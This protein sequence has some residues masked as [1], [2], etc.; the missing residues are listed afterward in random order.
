M[1]QICTFHKT[2]Q[3][4]GHIQRNQPCEDAS[5]SYCDENG[6][7]FIA[8]VADGHGQAKSF[9]SGIGSQIAV[10][11]ALLCLKDAAEAILSTPEETESFYCSLLESRHGRQ[12]R[13]KQ[14]T[15]TILSQWSDGIWQDYSATPPTQDELGE[16]AQYY[17]DDGNVPKI[18]GTTLIAALWLPK[19]LLLLQQGDGRCDVLYADG[20]VDQPIPWDERCEGNR[21]SS[22]CDEDAADRIRHCVINLEEKQV[23]A[24]YLGS[25]GVED[26]YRNQ[27]GTHIFYKDLSCVLAV[28]DDK[29]FDSYL[30]ELLPDFSARGR[31]GKNGSMDDVSVAGIAD[32]EKLAQ[33]TAG[34]QTDILRFQLEEDIFWKEDTLRSKMR[35]HDILQKRSMEA[36]VQLRQ[37][38]NLLDVQRNRY[39]Q[40]LEQRDQMQSAIEQLE[41]KI[42]W[43]NT[44][45]DDILRRINKAVKSAV[46]LDLETKRNG[47]MTN[48]D[49]LQEEI[50]NQEAVI[51]Q[52]EADCQHQ[53]E[54]ET[55]VKAEFTEY[56]TQYQE[57][58]GQ[59][60]TLR[61]ELSMLGEISE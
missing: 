19:C 30:E 3:G 24:C 14:L 15:D 17:A 22:V 23:A 48:L 12:T 10:E 33:L 4:Y 55:N 32:K 51:Q 43:Q 40:M 46:G 7:F 11:V 9:R 6:K 16:Y 13:I 18:Y 44:S 50:R 59:I 25:D 49:A 56:D 53:A 35:K 38:E 28:K 58:A 29:D 57:I 37:I 47:M 26:A 36:E 20:S 54:Y 42:E 60:E 39:A 31:F 27:E 61:M 52:L 1:G 21:T 2:A 5:V 34:Y 8:A 41:R 45:Q